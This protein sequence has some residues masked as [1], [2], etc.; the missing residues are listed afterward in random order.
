MGGRWG[1]WVFL[2]PTELALEQDT[3]G[4]LGQGFAAQPH[5]GLRFHRRLRRWIGADGS[6]TP[7]ASSGDAFPLVK[8]IYALDSRVD[9]V[10]QCILHLF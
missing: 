1:G 3:E 8:T 7:I 4:R 10:F 2:N 9:T 5:T 6:P